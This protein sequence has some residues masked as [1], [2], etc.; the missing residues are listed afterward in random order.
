MKAEPTE[1]AAAATTPTW[2]R[3]SEVARYHV[4]VATPVATTPVAESPTPT[5]RHRTRHESKR[6]DELSS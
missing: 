6:Q 2:L 1:A 5:H 4:V 3:S